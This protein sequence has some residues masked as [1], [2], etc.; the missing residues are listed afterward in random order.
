[1]CFVPFSCF[2][3]TLLSFTFLFLPVPRTF[4]C[5]LPSPSLSI[6]H[7]SLLH[8]LGPRCSSWTSSLH[9]HTP[10]GSQPCPG[11]NQAPGPS[12]G[13]TASLALAPA[14]GQ[15]QPPAPGPGPGSGQANCTQAWSSNALRPSPLSV[16]R[17]LDENHDPPLPCVKPQFTCS[18]VCELNPT[19]TPAIL[20]V[21]TAF[22]YT[23]THLSHDLHP[24]L[25]PKPSQSLTGNQHLA[26]SYLQPQLQLTES[27]VTM[28][29]GNSK[30]R[31]G[32]FIL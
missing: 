11:P 31:H 22:T 25:S 27:S 21:P 23:T 14:P 24:L 4:P 1:M 20:H 19:H 17:R 26:R 3:L 29:T 32:Q 6:S 15:A 5:F 9:P 8:P 12:A 18:A 2:N 16:S 7:N 10:Q 13:P 30:R 28:T